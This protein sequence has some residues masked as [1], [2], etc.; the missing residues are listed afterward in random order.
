MSAFAPTGWSPDCRNLA[1]LISSNSDI[2]ASKVKVRRR[3]VAEVECIPANC[4]GPDSL[5]DA[6]RATFVGNHREPSGE[7]RQF[8]DRIFVI[9][10]DQGILV[11][12]CGTRRIDGDKSNLCWAN[13]GGVR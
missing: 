4:I 11:N 5:R 8:C 2:V 3:V 9:Y 12:P 7:S 1:D 13:F 6:L 10:R